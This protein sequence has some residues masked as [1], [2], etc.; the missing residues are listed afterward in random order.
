M[1]DPFA[2][3]TPEELVR[4]AAAAE[5]RVALAPILDSLI[6]RIAPGA[7]TFG[8]FQN[9]LKIRPQLALEF[10]A[11]LPEPISA[12]VVL[13]GAQ[14]LPDRTNPLPLRL[15]VAGKI[16]GSLPDTVPAVGPIVRSLT[17]GLTRSR[18]L[19]RM[20]QLQSRVDQCATL[21]SMVDTLQARVKLKC[22]KCRVKLS[23]PEF[24]VHLWHTHRLV[25]ERGQARE[26]RAAVEQLFAEVAAHSPK[27]P[28]PETAYH[29]SALY[30][31]QAE[32]VQVLQ[33]LAAA[34][35]PGTAIP[36]PLFE[37]ARA[38]RN[39]LCPACLAPLPDRIGELPPAL[40]S[41]ATRLAGEGFAV[42]IRE[43]GGRQIADV[44][45]PETARTIAPKTQRFWGPRAI[46]V[47]AASSVLTV[48]LLMALLVP[49]G[50]PFLIA[51]LT[52]GA[53]W[54]VY[55]GFRYL[56]S[57]LTG[58]KVRVVDLMWREIAG[59]MTPNSKS[60]R[61]LTR[62]AITSVNRGTPGERA[63]T[64]D[65]LI[66]AAEGK[67]EPTRSER[68][69]LA[70]A[71]ALQVADSALVG[72]DKVNGLV[73]LFER[74]WREELS[75]ETGE[76][77]AEIVRQRFQLTTGD[78]ARLSLLVLNGAFEN[79][80]LPPDFL[81]LGRYAPN[82]WAVLGDPSEDYLRAA[83]QIWRGK[84]SEP[85]LGNGPAI[86]LFDVAR[87]APATARKIFAA[88]PDALLKLELPEAAQRTLGDVLLTPRGLA[89]GSIVLT[90]PQ[91]AMDLNRSPRGSGWI[92]KLGREFINLDRKVP[93]DLIPVF[94]GW[95]T[96]RAK[97]W[98]P[99]A[100]VL[101]RS[102]T[103]KLRSLLKPLS[104]ACALCGAESI[105]RT[106]TVGD[107]WPLNT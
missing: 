107:P 37:S 96:Y 90:D 91:L 5:D 2:K 71:L 77:L 23:R 82:L 30:F 52:T 80:L 45:T 58:A 43:A 57:G 29:A 11:R 79:G 62:L 103:G 24:I 42:Q 83:C 21:D 6:P 14:L 36:L 32:P 81:W 17:A 69:M 59:P 25:Y 74:V 73:R 44:E 75:L 31:P 101:T 105:G 99:Q 47:V 93:S 94:S 54:L 7:P 56:R 55:S 64:L 65:S 97:R 60:A 50:S 40:S 41:T 86:T 76:A 27:A 33:A 49:K 15:A 61:F 95:L 16:L 68:L 88:H 10:T 53:G 39:W 1:A 84:S 28:P 22:P 18:T 51:L 35:R 4:L 48:G 87:K 70:A 106:A 63:G 104:G 8:M 13:M 12:A 26:P 100:E 3:R 20:I 67:V 66:S 72:K 34:R 102:N 9:L 38:G 78:S 46:G 19:E 98:L 89:I 85:W 92:L